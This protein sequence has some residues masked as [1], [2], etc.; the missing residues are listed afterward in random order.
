MLGSNT[1]TFGPRLPPVS[2]SPWS[3]DAK[4][5][6]LAPLPLGA[7]L[8]PSAGPAA[9]RPSAAIATASART[10][11]SAAERQFGLVVRSLVVRSLIMFRLAFRI[12]RRGNL[13]P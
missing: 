3:A 12:G 7:A 5:P 9:T 1:I 2:G 11:G 6:A 10:R 4:A 8:A 13:R